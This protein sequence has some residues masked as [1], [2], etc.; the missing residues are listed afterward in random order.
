MSNKPLDFQFFEECLRDQLVMFLEGAADF[1]WTPELKLIING[2]ASADGYDEINKLERA[3]LVD[4]VYQTISDTVEIL[5]RHIQP[6]LGKR[7]VSNFVEPL[8]TDS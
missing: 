4:P 1:E 5:M 7:K 6:H 3:R 8:D 2:I